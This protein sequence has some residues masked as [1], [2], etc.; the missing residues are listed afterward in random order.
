MATTE[1]KRHGRSAGSTQ[2]DEHD[3]T[4]PVGAACGAQRD[5]LAKASRHE[6]GLAERRDRGAGR[7]RHASA[8]ELLGGLD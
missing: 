8:L 5:L 6:R 4:A 3:Q 7:D 1:A 2:P